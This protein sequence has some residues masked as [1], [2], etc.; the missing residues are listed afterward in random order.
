MAEGQ[1]QQR[2]APSAVGHL[3]DKPLVHLLVY[4]RN[5]R[6]TGVIEL[7]APE[8]SE[9][10]GGTITFWRGRITD[11]RTSP[12]VAYFGT[13]AYELGRIDSG[14]LDVTLLELAKTKRKHGEILVERGSLTTDQRDEILLEQTCRKVHHLCGLPPR[15]QFAFY[16]SVPNPFEPESPIDP[17]APVWRALRTHPLSESAREVAARFAS[18]PLRMI[19]EGPIGKAGL[20]A[21]ERAL[22]DALT[23][24]PMNTQQLRDT[25]HLPTDRTDQLVYL[26]VITK[27]AEPAPPESVREMAVPSAPPSSQPVVVKTPS[28]EMRHASMSFR[29]PSLPRIPGLRT[30]SSARMM[31]ASPSSSRM[32]AA[33]PSSQMMPAHGPAELGASAVAARAI[34]V[35]NE[36]YFFALGLADNAPE[37]AARAAYFRLAKLWHPDRLPAELEPFR[38]EVTKIFDHLSTAHRV[39]TDKEER[40]AWIAS[41]RKMGGSSGVAREKKDVLKEIERA[42]LKPDWV[43]V[44]S[45]ADELLAEHADDIEGLA[46]SGMA[47]ANGGESLEPELRAGLALLDSA[48]KRDLYT[49]RT[50][51][52]RGLLHKRLGN[53]AGAFRD[54][55]RAAQLDPKHID[56]QR[57]L[58]ILE[59]RARKGSGEHALDALV[60]AK[61]K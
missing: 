46:F 56:A 55:T 53:L 3:G 5:K 32:M 8:S 37:E 21:E 4:A 42:L 59:M 49:E 51:Y 47:L 17:I 25:R 38:A 43:T 30:D 19:N 35:H 54:F 9:N 41:G 10:A 40:Q 26:L 31:A 34:N 2:P 12:P 60:R 15:T 1:S 44:K 20:S 36:D 39:L 13:V 58:R 16:E 7:R 33:S 27:C 18:S 57:E 11:V 45:L 23:D 52:Y 50:F 28:G 22:C 61:K 48:I 14:T 24:R 6:L 29:V